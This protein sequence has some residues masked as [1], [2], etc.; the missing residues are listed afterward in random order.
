MDSTDNRTM[1][2][3]VDRTHPLILVAKVQG[4]PLQLVALVSRP[5]IGGSDGDGIA[6]SDLEA[7][8]LQY[9]LLRNHANH[10]LSRDESDPRMTERCWM[11]E[12][13]R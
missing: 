12:F 1:R 2:V 3:P 6:R 13:Q 9:H 10:C 11:H 8:R 5:D 4:V 7:L